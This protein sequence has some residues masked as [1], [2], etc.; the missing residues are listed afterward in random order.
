MFFKILDR[1]LGL[2]MMARAGR[3]FA[4]AHGAQFPAER[5]LGDRDPDLK[6]F[7]LDLTGGRFVAHVAAAGAELVW[8]AQP[9]P[10]RAERTPHDQGPEDH[11]RQ[12]WAA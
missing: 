9:S 5:L 12:G 6:K 7:E 8:V 11:P 2:R 3:E 10:R 4:V 1:A